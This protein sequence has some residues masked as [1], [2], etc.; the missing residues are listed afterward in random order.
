MRYKTFRSLVLVVAVFGG[1]PSSGPSTKGAE[2]GR[3]S[4][5]RRAVAAP[6]DVRRPRRASPR[7]PPARRRSRLA[8]GPLALRQMDEEILARVAENISG[9]KAKDA[10]RGRS[11]KVNL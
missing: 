9:D 11:W 7:P 4:P 1:A 8:V 6:V 3:A 2:A 10:V 5:G